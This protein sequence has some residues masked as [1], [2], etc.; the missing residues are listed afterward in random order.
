[1]KV[2]IVGAGIVGI[3]TAH[4]LLD[5]GHEVLIIDKEGPAF[6]PSRGN[7]GWIAHTVILPIASPKNLRQVPKFLADPLG[8]LAIRPAYLPKLLPWLVRFILAARPAAYERSVQ[9]LG[10]LQQRAL[11]TWRKLAQATNLSRH[12]HRNGGLYAFT[13]NAAFAE[14][15]TFDRGLG[16]DHRLQH[17]R[18]RRSRSAGPWLRGD[19]SRLTAP[20]ATVSRARRGIPHRTPDNHLAPNWRCTAQNSACFESKR[21]E[22][23]FDRNMAWVDCRR[24]KPLVALHSNRIPHASASCRR[25]ERE[26]VRGVRRRQWKY[27]SSSS[28]TG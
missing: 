18:H 3:A 22:I 13:D 21:S 7:A 24:R 12:I 27:S 2:A 11:P 23:A 1:M 17:R 15:Y 28:S 16:P 8:P 19:R 10:A 20:P 14:H 5:D 25:R 4:A 6:G 26:L 9:G